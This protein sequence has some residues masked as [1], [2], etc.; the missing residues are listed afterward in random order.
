VR[1]SLLIAL[2]IVIGLAGW[3]ASGEL[4]A[5]EPPPAAAPDPAPA[6]EAPAFHVSVTESRAAPVERSLRASGRTEPARKVELRA[7]VAGRVVAVPGERGSEVEAGALL[8]QLDERDRAARL[9]FAQAELTQREIQ[10][11]ASEQLKSKGF[12]AETAAAESTA[13]LEE[14][15]M[16]VE[17]AELALEH[18]RVT[19]PFAGVLDRRPVEIGDYVDAG[20]AVAT[21]LELDPLIIV[22]DVAEAEIGTVRVGMPGAAVTIGGQ[23]LEGRVRY[24]ASEADPQTRTFRV[25]LEVANPRNRVGAGISSEL[26]LPLAPVPAHE[27]SSAVLVLDDAGRLGVQTVDA[28][29]VVR[30][31][32]AEIV[33]GGAEAVWL[34]GLPERIRLITVGQGFVR[35]GEK[36]IPVLRP[37]LTAEAGESPR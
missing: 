23:R 3:L 1:R 10:Y 16:A 25:E 30:F 36:V 15:R 27:V 12:Q 14:A 31:L 6:A 13:R 2:A 29:D 37:P 19:A 33:R 26:V 11:R 20:E 24:V 22:A 28:D 8:V 7:E 4:G 17:A 9:R 35:P 21:I 32:P 18:T 34:A 5:P